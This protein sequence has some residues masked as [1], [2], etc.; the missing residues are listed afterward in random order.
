MLNSVSTLNIHAQQNV[1]MSNNNKI[2]AAK[3]MSITSG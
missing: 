2:E 1:E 3:K